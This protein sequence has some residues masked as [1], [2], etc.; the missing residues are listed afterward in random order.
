LGS[1]HSRL[2][3]RKAGALLQLQIKATPIEE[4]IAW[5]AF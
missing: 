4:K 5:R 1:Y 3:C 2:L